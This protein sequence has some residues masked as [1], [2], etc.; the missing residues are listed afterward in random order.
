M[1]RAAQLGKP[2]GFTEKQFGSSGC[3]GAALRKRP[4]VLHSRR[5]R[6]GGWGGG[7]AGG[8]RV[9]ATLAANGSDV[10]SCLGTEF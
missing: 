6:G 5:R 1:T 3:V 2:L 8:Q 10:L 7:A 4:A 9:L